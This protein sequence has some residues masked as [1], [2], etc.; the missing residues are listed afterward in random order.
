MSPEPREFA[1]AA[2]IRANRKA[3]QDYFRTL[4]AFVEPKPEPESAPAN[5]TDWVADDEYARMLATWQPETAPDDTRPIRT[6]LSR[7]A[8]IQQIVARRYNVS[9]ED[10]IS[11]RRTQ[12]VLL[13]RQI[14][15][16]LARTLTIRSLPEI[17][18]LFGNRDHTTVMHAVRRIEQR[19]QSDQKCAG[20]VAMFVKQIEGRS[21]TEAG[22]HM[23]RRPAAF[24]QAQY[25]EV[26]R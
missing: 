5:L 2:E 21:A 24:T 1:S 19:M 6:S 14:A 17:G 9:R 23:S 22:G 12:H 20:D 26:A 18:R 8:Y 25:Q 15:I 11:T 16:Y 13:P 10:L 7:I 4:P 3:V